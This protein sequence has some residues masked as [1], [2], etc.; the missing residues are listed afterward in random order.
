[1][2]FSHSS[3]FLSIKHNPKTQQNN[4]TPQSPRISTFMSL[5]SRS[6]QLYTRSLRKNVPLL[7]RR[8]A[9]FTLP[10][11][12]RQPFSTRTTLL[13]KQHASSSQAQSK[14]AAQ[15]EPVESAPELP[16]LNLDSL[17][18]GR[19][20][21]ILVIVL[22]SIFGTMETYFYCRAIWRWWKGSGDEE[23]VHDAK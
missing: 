9:Q 2:P 10:N 15:R 18:L 4:L 16:A 3:V 1:M 20:M 12:A 5:A 13:N 7:T 17:G 23:T 8:G 11:L 22:L 14:I 19:N 6:L 21:K